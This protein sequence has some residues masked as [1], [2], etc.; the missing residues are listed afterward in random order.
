[1]KCL[2][3]SDQINAFHPKLLRACGQR[4]PGWCYG[5]ADCR[6]PSLDIF[7]HWEA[8]LGI[9][10][11]AGQPKGHLLAPSYDMCCFC[12]LHWWY[13][14]DLKRLLWHLC[15]AE[16]KLKKLQSSAWMDTDRAADGA[17]N[18]MRAGSTAVS[19]LQLLSKEPFPL[20]WIVHTCTYLYI[21][22]HTHRYLYILVQPRKAEHTVC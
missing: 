6:D 21:I 14:S 10:N 3:F 16:W 13:C 2:L 7:K 15:W 9:S 12:L 20:A 17:K 1:M 18:A 19:C 4:R 22:V 11:A 5:G 8:T